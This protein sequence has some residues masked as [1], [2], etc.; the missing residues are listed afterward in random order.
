MDLI[1]SIATIVS[2]MCDV[3]GIPKSLLLPL[4]EFPIVWMLARSSQEQSKVFVESYWVTKTL[5]NDR[6]P[7]VFCAGLVLQL[8]RF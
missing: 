4:T 7:A 3:F 6:W 2:A 8:Y 5:E 1:V